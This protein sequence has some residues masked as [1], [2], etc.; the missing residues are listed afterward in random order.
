MNALSMLLWLAALQPDAQS[1]LAQTTAA[2]TGQTP[3]V[4][5]PAPPPAAAPAEPQTPRPPNL[6]DRRVSPNVAPSDQSY[7]NRVLSNFQ[8]TQGR[9]G[10]YDGRWVL[11]GSAGDMFVL[12]LTDPGEGGKIEG[13]WR[14][15]R[16][17]G[18][19]RSGLIDSVTREGDMITV[20]F[21]E[22]GA[23]QPVEVRLRSAQPG[24]WLGEVN[25]D[26]GR[27]SIVMHRSNGLE[28]QAATAPYVPSRA[29]AV[30]SG[31][32]EQRQARPTKQK[33]SKA[34]ARHGPKAGKAKKGQKASAHK[35][36]R[37]TAKSHSPKKQH[38]ASKAKTTK[39]KQSSAPQRKKK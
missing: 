10:P 21:T 33:A 4:E 2:Q 34:K 39:K 22:E 19:G 15:L 25:A 1:A 3:A 35:R 6:D 20:R 23:S 9:Q 31:S 12:Q 16:R 30:S 18:G 38:S 14:D 32:S 27:S 5:A 37:A 26:G 36:G 17:T 8:Q 24:G 11:S 7:Q 29:R 28:T 13:A